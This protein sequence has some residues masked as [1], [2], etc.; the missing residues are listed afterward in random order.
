MLV[1]ATG[2]LPVWWVVV[3]RLRAGLPLLPYAPRRPVPWDQRDLAVLVLGFMAVAVLTGAVFFPDGPPTEEPTAQQETSAA[4][5]PPADSGQ[6]GAGDLSSDNPASAVAPPERPATGKSPPAP[7][8]SARESEPSGSEPRDDHAQAT[9]KAHPLVQLLLKS[10]ARW[11]LALAVLAATVVAPFSE[12]LFFRVVLQGWLERNERRWLARW[13]PA[14]RRWRGRAAVIVSSLIFAGVHFFGRSDGVLST[15][16]LES[17]LKMNACI[18]AMAALLTVC[19]LSWQCQATERD[20]GIDWRYWRSD[21][22]VGLAAFLSVAPVVYT[23]QFGLNWLFPNSPV[24]LDPIPLFLLAL[25]LGYLY[26]R[27][28]RLFP[29]VVLHFGINAYSLLM[30]FGFPEMV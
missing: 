10:P 16:Q 22:V 25:V 28:H 8:V 14:A 11:V 21:L 23:L 30:L 5:P 26:R 1:L 19:Y 27:T 20:L 13:G 9:A 4:E 24:T 12:E 18:P 6:P 17:I 15:Q 29:S 7:S 2:S 3:S